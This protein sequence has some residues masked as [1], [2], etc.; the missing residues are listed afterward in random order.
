MAAPPEMSEA[1]QIKTVN[2]YFIIL[3]IKIYLNISYISGNLSYPKDSIGILRR[4]LLF[5]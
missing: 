1:D 5:S 2:T 4:K 3:Y